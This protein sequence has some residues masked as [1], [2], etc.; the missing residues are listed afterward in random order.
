MNRDITSIYKAYA[1]SNRLHPILLVSATFDSGVLRFWNGY[2][3]LSYDGNDYT[4]AGN[5]LNITSST[6]TEELKANGISIGLS[7]IST[8]IISIT[9]NQTVAGRPVDIKMGFLSGNPQAI[10][11]NNNNG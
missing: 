9:L 10:L 1:R 4:G 7:G 5:L 2:S 6:E 3:T 11:K 8:E